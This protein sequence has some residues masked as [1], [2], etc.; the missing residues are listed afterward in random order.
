MASSSIY[1]GDVLKAPADLTLTSLNETP[2]RVL[3]LPN[4]AGLSKNFNIEERMYKAF[5]PG[6]NGILQTVDVQKISE[7][8]Q[9]TM[10]IPAIT[11]EILSM[12]YGRKLETAATVNRFVSASNYSITGNT[13]PAANTGELGY[14][15]AA[16]PVGATASYLSGD[17]NKESQPLTFS[18]F[19]TFDPVAESLSF[20]VGANGAMK[21]SND[22]IGK[23]VAY[24]IP[25]TYSNI[26]VMGEGK[27]DRFSAN[28]TVVENNGQVVN[29][30]MPEAVIRPA[31]G[32]ITFGEETQITLAPLAGGR[33]FAEQIS[34]LG[35]VD[36][37]LE[38]TNV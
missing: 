38:A 14:A 21:F 8:P 26:T 12:R 10:T 6:S 7:D 20:A 27:F 23:I 33:C 29:F 15:I 25:A 24:K 5:T 19:A 16:D 9:F 22:L 35:E 3:V 28:L 13:V 18:T 30:Y 1:A 34:Y 11:P 31:A 32:D 4:P 36:R 17:N 37:C 2:E